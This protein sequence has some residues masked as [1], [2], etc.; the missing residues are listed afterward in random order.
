M[1]CH[2]YVIRLVNSVKQSCIFVKHAT[3][4]IKNHKNCEIEVYEIT[5][6]IVSFNLFSES[7]KPSVLQPKEV[8]IERIYELTLRTYLNDQLIDCECFLYL[9]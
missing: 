2:V 4:T 5:Y 1:F 3:K 9:N 6:F 7:S 8:V